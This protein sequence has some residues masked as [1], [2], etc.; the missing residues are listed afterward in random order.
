[1]GSFAWNQLDYVATTYNFK[2][3]PTGA[4]TVWVTGDTAIWTNYY[5]N[6]EVTFRNP[7]E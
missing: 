7:V 6:S 5:S 2:P 3:H 4:C 1:L